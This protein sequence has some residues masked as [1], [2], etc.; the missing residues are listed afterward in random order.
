MRRRLQQGAAGVGQGDILGRVHPHEAGGRRGAAQEVPEVRAEPP[1]GAPDLLGQP[2]LQLGREP[3]GQEQGAEAAGEGGDGGRPRS[4]QG[5][6]AAERRDERGAGC[7]VREGVGRQLHGD[8][9]V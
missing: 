5:E 8:G 9:D 1:R 3:A 6:A 4:V 2:G 7:C